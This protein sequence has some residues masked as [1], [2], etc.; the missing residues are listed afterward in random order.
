MK[1]NFTETLVGIEKTYSYDEIQ[2]YVQIENKGTGSLAVV[3]ASVSETIANGATWA[4][5]VSLSELTITA[6]GTVIMEVTSYTAESSANN[7]AIEGE[8]DDVDAILLTALVVAETATV[9]TADA[10]GVKGQVKWD[11]THIFVCVATDTWIRAALVA[12]A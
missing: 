4:S 3:G 9:A 1:A 2:T 12:W 8:I 7:V 10:T 6:T 11:A 5:A